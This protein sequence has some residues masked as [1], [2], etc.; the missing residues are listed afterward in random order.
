MYG[1]TNKQSHFE[2]SMEVSVEPLK[3]KNLA[4]IL[5]FLSDTSGLTALARWPEK[6]AKFLLGL[7]KNAGANAEV[8]SIVDIDKYL[9]YRLK[10]WIK[11]ILS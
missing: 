4:Q 7:L 3:A 1:N 5:V 6:S 11:Q 9:R 10:V 8:L 2:D